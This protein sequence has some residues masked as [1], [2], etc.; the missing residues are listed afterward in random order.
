LESALKFPSHSIFHHH[1]HEFNVTLQGELQAW[2]KLLYHHFD[3][4]DY[5][6]FDNFLLYDLQVTEAI[7]QVKT[8]QPPPQQYPI[9]QGY[10]MS[11]PVYPQQMFSP[12]PQQM[13]SP[14]PQQMFSPVPQQMVSP[15]P[16]QMFSPGSQ[17]VFSQVPQQVVSPQGLQPTAPTDPMSFPPQNSQG[18]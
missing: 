10:P 13:F 5:S 15:D 4:A 14:V 16:Q 17:Q 7:A 2:L 12:V 11:P 9:P 8:Q 18:P 3:P 1:N 6:D